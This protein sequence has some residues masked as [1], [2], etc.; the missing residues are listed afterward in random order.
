MRNTVFFLLF[1]LSSY[2]S[3][4]QVNTTEYTK[5]KEGMEYK[6]ISSGIT[7]QIKP[8]D[9]LQ[10]NF[11]TYCN[12]GSKDSLLNDSRQNGAPVI[13]KLDSATIPPGYYDILRQVKNNDS[14]VI[15]ILT[16]SIFKANPEQMPPFLKKGDHVMTTFKVLNIYTSKE[17]ADSAREFMA[18]EMKEKDSLAA[19][20]ETVKEES[21]LKDYFAKNNIKTVK[22]PKGTYVSIL[23]NGTGKN[24]TKNDK[25]K[26]NYTGKTLAGKVFDSNTDKAF[27]HVE[28]FE[29]NLATSGSVIAGWEE[30]LLLLNKGAQAVFYIPSALAYGSHGAGGDI[31]PNEIL[32]FEVEITSIE[33]ATAGVIVS[34]APAVK[35]TAPVSKAKPKATTAKPKT[36]T[37][38]AVKK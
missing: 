32:I 36:T 31:G 16:D 12:T 7:A 9:F 3:V 29:V 10:L 24:A 27:N 18:K 11:A 37:K 1:I 6:I 38:K 15:R 23:K 21:I 30:G 35:K 4:A 8:G 28:P 22:A 34:P 2:M 14:V 5:G 17:Q 33:P 13:E 19:I 25:V 20:I 26:V